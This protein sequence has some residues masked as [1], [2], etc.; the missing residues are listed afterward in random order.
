MTLI[1]SHRTICPRTHSFAQS[2]FFTK[3]GGGQH[4]VLEREGELKIVLLERTDEGFSNEN[5]M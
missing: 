2:H 3:F 4:P 5:N 1:L